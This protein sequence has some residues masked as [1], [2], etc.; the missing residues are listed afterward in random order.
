[1]EII[2][3]NL[4]GWLELQLIGRLDANWSDH[5][6]NAIE[7]AV[8]A[9]QHHID[10][11]LAQVNYVS[12][13]GIRMLVKHYK[14]LKAARGALRIV[15]IA[16][17]VLSVLQL[18]GLDAMLVV[19][20]PSALA[21]SANVS[22]SPK[23]VG[24]EREPRRWESKGVVFE[25]HEQQAGGVLNFQLHGRPERFATGQ[26]SSDQSIRVR[27][28]TDVF[29]LGLG[30]FGS[31]GQDA[32]TRFGDF[33]AVAGAA[34]TQPTDGSSVPDFQM[35]E[36]QFVPEVNLLYGLTA[37]GGFA[38]LLRFEAGKSER[39]VIAL[40]D[41]IDAALENTQVSSAGFVILAESAC[42]VGATLRR[43]PALASGQSP[44]V[45]PGVRDWLSFTTERTDERNF[46]L[47]V[48]FA[49]RE[50][51]SDSA[52]FLRTIG[53]GTSA[54]GHFHAAVFPYRPVPKGNLNLQE[55]IANLM[56]TESALTVMH[57]LADEREF[58]GVGQTDLMRGA[59]WVAPLKRSNGATKT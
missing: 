48:G 4:E 22:E 37:R 42:M 39:N 43:S 6:G 5:V 1:M 13:A 16:D 19:S 24:I 52:P 53:P 35:S 15:R 20:A 33:L 31:G 9:G 47:I 14:R 32:Q 57:L 25:S 41:L 38:Q 23:P 54:Q 8:R 34:V 28:D 7:S 30:A 50:P 45:F 56:S 26:L 17:A 29:G 49:E 58:E 12:S 3:K 44:W 59:C 46:S 55:T 18:S 10:L 36:G 51:V 21:P 2:Q 27:F 40:S 11:D